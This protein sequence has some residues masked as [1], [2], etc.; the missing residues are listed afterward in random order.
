MAWSYLLVV[1]ANLGC[2]NAI[3]KLLFLSKL[4]VLYLSCFEL[5]CNHIRFS[6]SPIQTM[7]FS[8]QMLRARNRNVFHEINERECDRLAERW[9]S[10]E[11]MHAVSQFF[12]RTSQ[13]TFEPFNY[14]FIC[15]SRNQF[16]LM[17][18]IYPFL[19][20]IGDFGFGKLITLLL[21]YLFLVIF[22]FTNL[23]D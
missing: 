21:L 18:G 4:L 19:Q 6:F 20:R 8:K 17:T 1:A 13:W 14:H 7:Q 5:C 9:T 16:A 22:A 12:Q 15:L 23:T 10:Q 2:L 3:G 11:C